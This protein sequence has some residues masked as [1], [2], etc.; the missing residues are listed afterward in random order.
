MQSVAAAN[1]PGGGWRAGRRGDKI[2]QRV[3]RGPGAGP[4]RGAVLQQGASSEMVL[5]EEAL[6]NTGGRAEGWGPG[7]GVGSW[8]PGAPNAATMCMAPLLRL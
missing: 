5:V 7:K 1:Q 2:C 4:G 8:G 3:Q 6:N